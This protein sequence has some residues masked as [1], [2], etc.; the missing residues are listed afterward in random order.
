MRVPACLL[1]CLALASATR[2]S[3]VNSWDASIKLYEGNR[4]V[5]H[6]QFFADGASKDTLPRGFEG[7]PHI[8]VFGCS[9]VCIPAFLPSH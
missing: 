8:S 3:S 6:L 7:L 2:I 4:I 9:Y 5:V 1:A